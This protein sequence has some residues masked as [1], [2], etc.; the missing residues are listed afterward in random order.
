MP[1]RDFDM[2][3]NKVRDVSLSIEQLRVI[4]DAEFEGQYKEQMTFSRD[5]FM[6]SFYLCG[7]NLVD[8]LRLDLPKDSIR[9]LRQK[10][11]SRRSVDESTEFT[12]QPEARSKL[13]KDGQ[14]VYKKKYRTYCSL[15][16]TL[17][18]HLKHVAEACNIDCR[19]IFYSAR[20]TFAQLANELMVKDSIIE[21]CIGDPI[22][23]TSCTIATI[24]TSV[25]GWQM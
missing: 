13:V 21:Y 16:R 17:I 22:S 24:Y 2:P 11:A 8:I 6:L 5:L 23:I 9:F 20:K 19:L 14:I 10:T 18:R 1:F 4:R 3:K 15:T 12:I 25:N 7:M